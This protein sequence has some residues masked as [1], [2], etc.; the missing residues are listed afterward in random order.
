[1]QKK[2]QMTC[3]VSFCTCHSIL[4]KMSTKDGSQVDGLK[5]MATTGKSDHKR[6]KVWPQEEE[7]LATKKEDLATKIGRKGHKKR[8]I[9]QQEEEDLA[10]GGRSGNRRRKIWLQ[11]E[12]DLATGVGRSGNRSRKVGQQE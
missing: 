5:E 12:E 3:S 11:E 8:K 9:W 2:Q 1:M 7:Y 6:R 4:E 10:T